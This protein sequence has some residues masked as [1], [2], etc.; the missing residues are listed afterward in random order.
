MPEI[1]LLKDAGTAKELHD[2]DL[3]AMAPP[4]LDIAAYR[5][6]RAYDGS[7]LAHVALE[8]RPNAGPS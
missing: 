5:A 3:A 4:V 7:H 8:P 2:A 6:D 1:A